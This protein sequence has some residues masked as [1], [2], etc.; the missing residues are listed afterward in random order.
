MYG[1]TSAILF[2]RRRAY[3][4]I[5]SPPRIIITLNCPVQGLVSYIGSN[6]TFIIIYILIRKEGG[7]ESL[8]LHFQQICDG[9][10]NKG[11]SP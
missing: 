5:Y 1:V 10:V 7:V 4:I 3:H 11:G 8:H 6:I 2:P 9:T